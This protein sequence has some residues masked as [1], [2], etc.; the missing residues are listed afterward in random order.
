MVKF[1]FKLLAKQK[2]DGSVEVEKIV[3]STIAIDK[4]SL[5][6]NA[7]HHA[8]L[9]D[10]TDQIEEYFLRYVYGD[11]EYDQTIACQRDPNGTREKYPKAHYNGMGS[12]SLPTLYRPISRKMAQDWMNEHYAKI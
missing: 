7:I 10:L 12:F 6:A 8:A 3:P 4:A 11:E 2:P 1:L 9:N 5:F